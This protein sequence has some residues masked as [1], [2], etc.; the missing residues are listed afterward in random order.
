MKF[1]KFVYPICFVIGL[2]IGWGAS[3]LEENNKPKLI[4]D[5]PTTVEAFCNSEAKWHPDCKK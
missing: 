2:A 5:H 3:V 4:Y 1:S